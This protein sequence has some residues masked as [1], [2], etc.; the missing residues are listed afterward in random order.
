MQSFDEV[1]ISG[2]KYTVTSKNN[3]QNYD[4]AY[5]ISLEVVI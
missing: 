2:N 5:D 3:I 1:E 4:V